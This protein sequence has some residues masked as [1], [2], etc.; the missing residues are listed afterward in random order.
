MKYIGGDSILYKKLYI[1][2]KNNSTKI[3]RVRTGIPK[4]TDWYFKPHFNKY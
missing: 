1:E 3:A 2:N 4:L